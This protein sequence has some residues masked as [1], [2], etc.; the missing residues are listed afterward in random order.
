M[1]DNLVSNF[2]GF[3]LGSKL[4]GAIQRLGFEVPTEIQAK[5]IPLILEGKDVVGESATGSGKTL[6]F[7]CGAIECCLPKQGVQALILVPT[8][9]LAEQVSKSIN[10]LNVNKRFRILQI[11][12]GVSINPQIDFL[13]SS[14]IV[15]ATPG[16]LKDHIQRGT[17]DL[18][19]LKLLVLDEAD[20]MLDMGFIPDVEDIV[21]R[22]PKKRQTL[23]FSATFPPAV[24]VLTNKFLS[25]PVNV[26]VDNQVDA[27]LLKQ[28]YYD[29]RRGEKL[30]LLV[31][32]IKNEESDRIMVF[33]N[34][35][36]NSDLVHQNLV[37]NNIKASVLHG[38]FTQASRT[39]VIDNFKTGKC[40]VLV[41]TDVAARGIHVDD[42]SH[43]YNYDMAKDPN[44]YV[45][46]I[47]RTAR[48]GSEGL[49]VNLVSDLDHDNFSRVFS[50]YDF[51]I[52]K[53]SPPED[54][55]RIKFDISKPRDNNDRVGSNRRGSSQGR[56]NNSGGRTG[57]RPSGRSGFSGNRN[58]SSRLRR[59]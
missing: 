24:R 36:M 22:C 57:S 49:V 21:K 54:M 44:D 47:G 41:C 23:L 46:R 8:R 45:H 11:Y 50:N 10:D 55:V 29:A 18:S 34:T 9:E 13:R 33:C 53:L 17:I 27:K 12:G 6:A 51:S 16:R 26:K 42:V 56:S 48:A 3:N 28:V 32:L 58:S 19:K 5:S 4:L 40:K 30:S 39:K 20:R 15:V 43:V 14:E 38:G 59:R 7:G 2:N 37:R 31:H 35:R 1:S 52:D 25:N